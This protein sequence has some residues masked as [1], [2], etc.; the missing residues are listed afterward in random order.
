[1]VK[2]ALQR[3]AAVRISCGLDVERWPAS[4]LPAVINRWTFLS[5][6]IMG[7]VE[8]AACGHARMHVHA[9]TDTQMGIIS[10]TAAAAA[11]EVFVKVWMFLTLCECECVY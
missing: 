11:Q 5:A 4:R 2:A 7:N 3:T 10:R 1:M 9:R 8:S 6:L